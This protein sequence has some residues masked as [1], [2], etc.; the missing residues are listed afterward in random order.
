MSAS[1]E[2]GLL[3]AEP[4][5]AREWDRR[6]TQPGLH[7]VLTTRWSEAQASEADGI[8]KRVMLGMLGTISGLWILDLGCGVGRLAWT[9]AEQGA[10]VVGLD[11]SAGMLARAVA[12][13]VDPAVMFV[14]GSAN[15]LPFGDGAFDRLNASYVLQHILDDEM[16]SK[17]LREIARVVRSG[18]LV[19]TVDGI[20]RTRFVPGTSKVTLV[21]PWSAYLSVMTPAF[22]VERVEEFA[23]VQDRYTAVLWRKRKDGAVKTFARPL[24]DGGLS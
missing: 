18:G 3:Q 24:D 2:S 12:D 6:S 4:A 8:Q 11:K 17:S 5:N 13:R 1:A 21:R 14:R 23:C 16:F 7:A 22:L 20:G 10:R 15:A 9:L 19:L